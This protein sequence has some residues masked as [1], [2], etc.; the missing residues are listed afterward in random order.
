MWC[1]KARNAR[2]TR[3]YATSRM[4]CILPRAKP[5]SSTAEN[6]SISIRVEL[7]EATSEGMN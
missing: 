6:S 5:S 1:A 2:V 4:S 7:N 3:N